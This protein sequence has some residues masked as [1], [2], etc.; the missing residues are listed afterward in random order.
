MED[1]K[2]VISNKILLLMIMVCLVFTIQVF[3][4]FRNENETQKVNYIKK[5]I[6]GLKQDVNKIY[7]HYDALGSKIDTF[8]RE[9]NTIHK[10]VDA[11]NTKIENLKK[12]EKVQ[13]DKF[14]S[15]DARMWEQYFTDRYSKKINTPAESGK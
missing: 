8:N 10:S 6:I 14:K 4:L 15:Y 3:N 5:E 7:K 12:Y 9:I 1:L 13:I 2:T 11:N